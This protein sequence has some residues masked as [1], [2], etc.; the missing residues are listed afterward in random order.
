MALMPEYFAGQRASPSRPVH[1]L[2][3]RSLHA[4]QRF[5]R[6]L[7]DPAFAC[8]APTV[9]CRRDSLAL[10]PRVECVYQ[11]KLPVQRVKD[12]GILSR[13]SGAPTRRVAEEFQWSAP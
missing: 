13:D 5:G 3:I 10:S 7:S 2:F 6:F 9:A 4:R 8:L 12:L 11:L 1:S